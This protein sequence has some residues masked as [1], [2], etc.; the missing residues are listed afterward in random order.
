MLAY[1]F[2]PFFSSRNTSSASSSSFVR[3]FVLS[4]ES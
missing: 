2:F 4:F 1:N 3:L